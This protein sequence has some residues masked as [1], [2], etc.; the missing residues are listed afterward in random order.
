MR[1]K[2]S[3]ELSNY[4]YNID[5]TRLEQA[6]VEL[7]SGLINV[8]K[9][10]IRIN[11]NLKKLGLESVDFLAFSEELQERYQVA[12]NP[13][14][15]YGFK[16]VKEL[17]TFLIEEH[18][19][20]LQVFA[21][22][23]KTGSQDKQ[24]FDSKKKAYSQEG[25]KQV[26]PSEE[27]IKAPVAIIGINGR[28]PDADNLDEYW[29]HLIA[30]KGCISKIPSDRWNWE[31]YYESPLK[32]SNK[33]NSKWGGF[34]KDI[35]SFDTGFFNISPRE[36]E[37]MDPQQRIL[38]EETWHL[39][40]DAGYSVSSLSGTQTGVFIG[41]CHDDYNELLIKNHM[42]PEL[43]DTTGA[44][45][46]VIPNRISYFLDLQG[47]SIA[48]DTACS[49]S[50]VAV[51][52]AIQSIEQ[53]ES[54]M[55][56]AGG[57]NI[58]CTPRRYLTYGQAGMLS[59]DGKCKTFDK[60]A[61][62]Y[63]RGEGVGVILLKSLS[64]AEADGD[65]IYAVIK[66]SAMNHGGFTSSLTVPNPIAQSNLLVKAYE[67][68]GIDPV[69]VTY[70]ETHGTGTSLGD[71]IEINGLKEAFKKLRKDKTTPKEAHC[72]LGSVKTHIGHLESAAGIAGLIKV[73]LSLQRK[74]LPGNLHY[75]ELNPYYR[76]ERQPFQDIK[77]YRRVEK[78]KR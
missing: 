61:N 28:F 76:V 34:L 44:S 65:R 30:G 12:V 2:P 64:Q 33:T 55:A 51:H 21:E 27:T 41:V 46:S 31:D 52:Q 42:T 73:V 3:K 59:N 22:E 75:K 7:L 15:L 1:E 48:T 20:S 39:L 35:K 69:T 50:L 10:D 8:K 11:T 14:K 66:G 78:I 37:L 70:I 68:A 71:P 16:N 72:A 18:I 62:G 23:D 9:N 40:E 24:I 4:S 6:V 56:I 58:C 17:T 60:S 77:R 5:I 13:S 54:S 57:V 74:K 32:N 43:Y 47:P 38:L 49:S 26:T 45:F 19:S 63:V 25:K 53:G 29:A 36:A 67:K